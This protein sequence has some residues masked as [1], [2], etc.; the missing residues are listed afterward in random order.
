VGLLLLLG[1]WFALQASTVINFEDDVVDH[2]SLGFVTGKAGGASEYLGIVEGKA[3]GDPGGWSI[4]GSNGPRMVGIWGG[5]NG[6]SGGWT[7]ASDTTY[8]FVAFT[9][10]STASPLF[11]GVTFDVLVATGNSSGTFIFYGFSN[12]VQVASQTV[13]L[14]PVTIDGYAEYEGSVALTNIDQIRWY[15]T[16]PCGLDNFSFSTASGPADTTPPTVTSIVRKT[17]SAQMVSTNKVIFEVTFSEA[18]ANVSAS[19]FAVTPVGASTVTGV[20]SSVSGGPQ[21]YQVKVGVTGGTGEFRLDVPR[22]K[23][24]N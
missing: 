5:W 10:V 8:G 16:M 20:V 11:V 24:N 23:V 3:N 18:V 7:D 2:A 19:Q 21:V 22:A 4:E 13:A 12:G 6:N 15:T 9:N 17:P 14:S 1:Q